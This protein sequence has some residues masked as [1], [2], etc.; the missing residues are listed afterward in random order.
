MS[1]FE[2]YETDA[3]ANPKDEKRRIAYSDIRTTLSLRYPGPLSQLRH[4]IDL[5]CSA[6]GF[7]VDVTHWVNGELVYSGRLVYHVEKHETKPVI[8]V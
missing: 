5:A 4:F 6:P 1:Y 2:W 7:P 8:F 3:E